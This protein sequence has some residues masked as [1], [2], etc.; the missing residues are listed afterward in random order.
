MK[1]L[2]LDSHGASRLAYGTDRLVF[3]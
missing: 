3:L 2:A 1:L